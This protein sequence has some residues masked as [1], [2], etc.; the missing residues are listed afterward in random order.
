MTFH[1]VSVNHLLKETHQ[2]QVAT[3]EILRRMS[4]QDLSLASGTIS[5]SFD[6]ADDDISI[7]QVMLKDFI[8]KNNNLLE[9]YEVAGSG[10]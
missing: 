1:I 3:K 4:T 5:Q 2:T 10:Y 8:I 7:M 6:S 9:K